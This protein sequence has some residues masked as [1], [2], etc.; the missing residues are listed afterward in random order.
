MADDPLFTT[1]E[2]ATWAQRTP[3]EVAADPFATVVIE[4]ASHLIRDYGLASWTAGNV[5][6]RAKLIGLLLARNYY[7]NPDRENSSNVGPIGSRLVDDVV[8][9]LNLTDEEKAELAAL[10][11]AETGQPDTSGLWVQSTTRGDMETD[12]RPRYAAT[13]YAQDSNGILLPWLD[14]NDHLQPVDVP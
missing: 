5:P 2:M 4:A 11:A 6:Y 1:A 12:M 13:R 14:E 9:G 7:V 10:A 3:D 8:R